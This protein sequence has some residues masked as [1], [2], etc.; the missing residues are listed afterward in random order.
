[1]YEHLLFAWQYKYE[2][3]CDYEYFHTAIHE[4]QFMMHRFWITLH[5]YMNIHTAIPVARFIFENCD[6]DQQ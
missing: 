1:M 5:A 3:L 4:S 2:Y 6:S